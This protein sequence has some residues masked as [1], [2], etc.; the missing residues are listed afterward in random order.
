MVGNKNGIERRRLG[1]TG[2]IGII[3]EGKIS[4][5]GACG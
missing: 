4:F 2:Q 3:T 1:F 5:S